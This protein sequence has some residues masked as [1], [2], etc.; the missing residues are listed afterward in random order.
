MLTSGNQIGGGIGVNFANLWTL[1]Q[2]FS[3]L[4]LYGL[5]KTP[6]FS[7]LLVQGIGFPGCKESL[8]S[9]QLNSPVKLLRQNFAISHPGK[10]GEVCLL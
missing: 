2:S 9:Q 5:T 7:L 1:S 10:T 4:F 8:K 6:K 3:V